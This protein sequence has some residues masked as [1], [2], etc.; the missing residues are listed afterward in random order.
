MIE[1]APTGPDE[2][3][4]ELGQRYASGGVETSMVD[5]LLDKE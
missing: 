2:R 3:A 5:K 1:A 4:G